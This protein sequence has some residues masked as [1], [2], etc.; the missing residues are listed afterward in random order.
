MF[1]QISSLK[2]LIAGGL[3]LA[4][5]IWFYFY[6]DGLKNKI[7]TLQ[8]DLKDSYIEVANEKL[9]STRYKNSLDTQSKEIDMLKHS[10]KLA[11]SKLKKWKSLPPKIKY[12]TITKIRE[13]KSSDECKDIKSVLNSVRS[14]DFDSL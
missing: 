9:Q 13:V 2:K 8:D 14:I 12:K 4:I 7:D 5:A 3:V 6:I 1:S 11:N 10:E